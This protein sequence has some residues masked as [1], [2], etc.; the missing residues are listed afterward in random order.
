MIKFAD[1]NE[2]WL[3]KMRYFRSIHRSLLGIALICQE[4]NLLCMPN[5]FWTSKNV[6]A[7]ITGVM[8][9]GETVDCW[10]KE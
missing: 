5:I 9:G 8:D 6:D 2:L 7:C 10:R 4:M 1:Q 3:A